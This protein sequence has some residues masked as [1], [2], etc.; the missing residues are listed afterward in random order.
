MKPMMSVLAV[1]LCL[2]FFQSD[3]LAAKPVKLIFDT[4]MGNDIDDALALAVIHAL[5]SRGE[6]ELLAV[7]SSKDNPWSILYCDVVNSFY[8]RSEIPLG[9]VSQGATHL[10]GSYTRKVVEM[11]EDGKPVFARRFQ[12]AEDIPDAVSVLRSTLAAQPDHSVVL[13]VVGFSTNIARLLQSPGDQISPLTGRELVSRKVKL[14]SQMIGRFDRD[15]PAE[16]HEYNVKLDIPAA[17]TV[18]ELWP[19]EIP[20]IVSGW[21]VGRSIQNRAVS[22]QND[23]GYVKYHPIKLGYEYWHKMP[24]DRPTYDLTSV[25]YAIRPERD[26][27]GVSKPGQF[28]INEVGKLEHTKKT[29]RNQQFLTLTPEQ[30]LRVQEVL[31]SL[32]SQPPAM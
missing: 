10:D 29:D 19:A 31:E 12:S 15:K 20:V 17:K 9:R 6:C 11:S 27:F 16:F 18:F 23:Y 26:Y 21:E 5:Q 24:Y 3:S 1:F 14:L 22:I 7:T 25:L 13:V 8:G 2:S 28:K 32:S 4:D 30:I